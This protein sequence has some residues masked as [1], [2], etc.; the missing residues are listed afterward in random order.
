MVSLKKHTCVRFHQKDVLFVC[1]LNV[2][3]LKAKL[4]KKGLSANNLKEHRV[5]LCLRSDFCVMQQA[6]KMNRIL[7]KHFGKFLMQ[8]FSLRKSKNR[9]N[10]F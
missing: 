7:F 8:T 6:S 2:I 1:V 10:V 9:N 4:P 5:C 3:S